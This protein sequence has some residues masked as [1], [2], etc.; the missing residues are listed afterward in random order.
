M[1][2]LLVW[3]NNEELNR[4]RKKGPKMRENPAISDRVHKTEGYTEGSRG[5]RLALRQA[6]L[7]E[8]LAAGS[9]VVT[10]VRA[11]R[12]ELEHVACHKKNFL[13]T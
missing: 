5:G 9:R 12:L 10:A 6:A 7:R 4:K 8:V 11:C 3:A 1:I 2:R 13:E